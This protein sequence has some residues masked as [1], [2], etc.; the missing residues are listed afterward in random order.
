M[1]FATSAIVSML[2]A[3]TVQKHFETD[4]QAACFKAMESAIQAKV[5][6]K[7]Q[8]SKGEIK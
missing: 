2:I 4:V 7:G 5:E 6:F 8:C 3:A 1:I